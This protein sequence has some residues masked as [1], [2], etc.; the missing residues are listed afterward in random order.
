MAQVPTPVADRHVHSEWSWD[1][2]Q[3]D[4]MAT[5]ARAVELGLPALAFT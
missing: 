3:G 4:M 2:A 1:A 5:C